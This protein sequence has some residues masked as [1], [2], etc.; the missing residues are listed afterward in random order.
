MEHGT[1]LSG[2][3]NIGTRGRMMVAGSVCV[4]GGERKTAE[5][6]CF[7]FRTNLSGRKKQRCK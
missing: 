7:E 3:Q 2:R 1:R 5:K 6:G 4:L